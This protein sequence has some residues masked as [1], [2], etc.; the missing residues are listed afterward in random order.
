M[1][2]LTL[3]AGIIL[4]VACVASLL[5]SAFNRFAYYRTLDGSAEL[6]GKMHQRMIVFLVTGI[7]LAAAGAACLI[8][9]FK[10]R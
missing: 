2:K 4:I 3:I 9:Y 8:I 6:Y 5:F 1:K 10:F 7:I